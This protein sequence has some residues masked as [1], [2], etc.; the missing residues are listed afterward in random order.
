MLSSAHHSSCF[1]IFKGGVTTSTLPC[2]T[3]NDRPSDRQLYLI[4]Q[5]DLNHVSPVQAMK[6]WQAKKQEL[7]V[8]R[9]YNQSGLDNQR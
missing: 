9:V 5:R 7:F 1:R 6:N 4:P 3:L 2:P 8:K